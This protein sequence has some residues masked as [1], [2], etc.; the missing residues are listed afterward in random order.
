MGSRRKIRLDRGDTL[1]GTVPLVLKAQLQS[2]SGQRGFS[3][4]KEKSSVWSW[5]IAFFLALIIAVVVVFIVAGGESVSNSL[6][7][8]VENIRTFFDVPQK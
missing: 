4:K 6:H 7:G 2:R 1:G 3:R 8:F 5:V